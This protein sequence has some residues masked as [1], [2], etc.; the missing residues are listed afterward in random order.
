[1]RGFFG[2]KGCDERFLLCT[3][4]YSSKMGRIKA[5]HFDLDGTLYMPESMESAL[6]NIVGAMVHAG[7]PAKRDEAYRALMEIR[8]PDTSARNH[9]DRLT[10]KFCGK[11]D[12]FLVAVGVQHYEMSKEAHVVPV[13]GTEGVLR[14]LYR[15][16][17]LTVVSNGRPKDQ[18]GKI[19]RLRLWPFFT[20]YNADFTVKRRH[21]YFTSKKAR[22][23]PSPYLWRNAHRALKLD[24]GEAAMVGDKLYADIYGANLLGMPTVRV[25]QGRHSLQTADEVFE[26]KIVSRIGRHDWDRYKAYLKPDVQIDNIT[27]L[28]RA[29]KYLEHQ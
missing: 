26:N 27:E 22:E 15:N 21:M 16:H 7:L 8:K 18:A 10:Q 25:M 11:V 13:D 4:F 28:P 17:V 29:I 24:Y 6:E 3:L 5:I 20:E 14:S 12:P 19:V 2:V 23:K 9:F 1:L